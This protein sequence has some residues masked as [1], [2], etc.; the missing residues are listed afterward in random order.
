MA[1]RIRS[2][3]VQSYNLLTFLFT[4]ITV[5]FAQGCS[6]SSANIHP[7]VF[8][9][10]T[11][12]VADSAAM[13]DAIDEE[14]DIEEDFVED[15]G[16]AVT[17]E[18]IIIPRT[19]DANYRRETNPALNRHDM[20]VTIMSFM[21]VR[22][23]KRGSDANGF[24]CSGYTSKIFRLTLDV[25]LPRSAREQYKIGETVSKD[26]LMFGDLVFFRQRRSGPAHVGIYVGDGLFAHAST[27]IGVTI[28]LMESKYYKRRY[29]G[30]RR[31]VE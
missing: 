11:I 9:A 15:T 29:A 22:Y 17:I 16:A 3:P 2:Y 24:D 20:L 6:S 5:G 30:A 23:K 27:S 14:Q 1:H 8:S 26:S 25:E 19:A 18:N 4:F 7:H 13:E 12:L 21:G 31:I 28:S 10:D